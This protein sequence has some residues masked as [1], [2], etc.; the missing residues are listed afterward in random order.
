MVRP[1]VDKNPVTIDEEPGTEVTLQEKETANFH[2][3]V[4]G[5]KGKVRDPDNDSIFNANFY[6]VV[7]I[8]G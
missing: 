7:S 2:A 6:Q 4:V 5:G 3:G 8:D 1:D